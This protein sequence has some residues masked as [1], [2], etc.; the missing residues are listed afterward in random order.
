MSNSMQYAH[1]HSL[2]SDIFI[3]ENDVVNNGLLFF[4]SVIISYF[5]KLNLFFKSI[6]VTMLVIMLF[7]PLLVLY[8][9]CALTLRPLLN[10]KAKKIKI[11]RELIE[12]RIASKKYD[13]IALQKDYRLFRIFLDNQ[14][15]NRK[16]LQGEKIFTPAL[17]NYLN[18]LKLVEQVVRINAFSEFNSIILTY[19]EMQELAEATQSFECA[20]EQSNV[21]N[22]HLVQLRKY[23]L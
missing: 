16:L 5:Q 15:K 2:N 19:D 22:D 1:S 13:K 12:Q 8:L 7:I 9:L 4:E 14:Y 20:E 3:N 11:M 18:E 17:D 23:R 21:Y 6:T 10:R